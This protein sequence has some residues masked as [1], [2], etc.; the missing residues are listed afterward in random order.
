MGNAWA[1]GGG[2][3]RG[4]RERRG[5]TREYEQSLLREIG[6]APFFLALGASWSSI[7]RGDHAAIL[8]LFDFFGTFAPDFGIVHT[9][10]LF[11]PP[12]PLFLVSAGAAQRAPSA[13][14]CQ[15]KREGRGKNIGARKCWPP[16][17]WGGMGSTIV[18]RK[19]W[20]LHRA[21]GGKSIRARGTLAILRRKCLK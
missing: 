12:L 2:Q 16:V 13:S 4:G 8:E 11:P 21:V 10:S 18:A 17:R 15:K 19:C 6:V 1:R 20:P 5:M 3:K 9:P 7:C 14:T